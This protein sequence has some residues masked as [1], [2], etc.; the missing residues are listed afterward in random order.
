MGRSLTPDGSFSYLPVAGFTGSDSFLIAM[1]RGS[2]LSASVEVLIEVLPPPAAPSPAPAV[3][4]APTPSA[5]AFALGGT[6][7]DGVSSPG[8]TFGSLGPLDFAFEWLIPEFVVTLPGLP[9]VLA[10][11][12]QILVGM[13]WLPLVRRAI[14]DF[15]VRRRRRLDAPAS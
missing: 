4:A 13:G 12:A 14:R 3:P 11:L 8:V 1:S 15:G 2:E 5:D 9:V 6:S 10:V 7:H